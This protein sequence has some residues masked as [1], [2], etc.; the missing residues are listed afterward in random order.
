MENERSWKN[1]ERKKDI[2]N[3]VK[4]RK[5]E[6]KNMKENTN[7]FETK[8]EKNSFFFYRFFFTV[9][10][11]EMYTIPLEDDGICI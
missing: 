10:I 5:K 9:E 7:I 2:K 11:G 6:K 1:T 3:E 4:K 8:E